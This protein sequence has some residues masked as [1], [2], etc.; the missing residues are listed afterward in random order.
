MPKGSYSAH[1]KPP[2]SKNPI[3]GTP[4]ISRRLLNKEQQRIQTCQGLLDDR[5]PAY[6][7]PRPKFSGPFSE[8]KTVMKTTDDTDDGYDECQTSDDSS[9]IDG[10]NVVSALATRHTSID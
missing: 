5:I 8:K 10:N 3:C 9:D 4:G 7:P 1:Y 2:S 6:P